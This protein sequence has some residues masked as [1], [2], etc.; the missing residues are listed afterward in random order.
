[1]FIVVLQLCILIE[2]CLT[3]GYTQIY[4]VAPANERKFKAAWH[5]TTKLILSQVTHLFFHHR[6]YTRL[7]TDVFKQCRYSKI[8][9]LIPTFTIVFSAM[10]SKY[11][12]ATY[13]IRNFLVRTA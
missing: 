13:A 3:S 8:F 1:M 7:N 6:R 12:N 10:L 9:N 11:T 2:C 5:N 4:T